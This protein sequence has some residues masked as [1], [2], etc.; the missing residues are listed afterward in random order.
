MKEIFARKLY[1]KE[2][3]K[4]KNIREKNN[5]RQTG[6]NCSKIKTAGLNVSVG[7]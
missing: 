3:G 1:E 7:Q 5:D 2:R 6:K 4:G